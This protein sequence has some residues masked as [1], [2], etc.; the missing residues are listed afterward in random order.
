MY[1][2]Q[3]PHSHNYNQVPYLQVSEVAVRPFVIENISGFKGPVSVVTN[4]DGSLALVANFEGNTVSVLD[5]SAKM[6]SYIPGFSSP[7]AIAML[8]GGT[9][10]LV[11]DIEDGTVSIID[12]L[13]RQIV[14]TINGFDQPTSI[15]VTPNGDKALVTNSGGTTVS[16]I[17]LHTNMIEQ[18]LPGFNYP[19]ALAVMDLSGSQFIVT[20]NNVVSIVDLTKNTITN[21]DGFHGPNSV[22]VLRSKPI[23]LVT[24]LDSNTVSII[25]LNTNR[26]VGDIPGFNRPSSIATDERV[27]LVTNSGGT[28]VSIID[29]TANYAVANIDGFNIPNSV[30]MLL[31]GSRALVTNGGHVGKRLRRGDDSDTLSIIDFTISKRKKNR[32]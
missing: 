26:V 1:F 5:L 16:I 28:T 13:A 31:D 21:I 7:Y 6:S 15:T 2:S 23:A 24:N 8:P 18:N 30:A 29:L 27:A 20:G 17:N 19:N 12:I 4:Y 3:R 10:A 32:R 25:D 14:R 11:T 22:V 9:T